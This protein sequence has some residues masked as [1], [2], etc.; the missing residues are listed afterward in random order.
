MNYNNNYTISVITYLYVIWSILIEQYC[1]NYMF[2][3]K[4]GCLE[5]DNRHQIMDIYTDGL[6]LW[7]HR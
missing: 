2:W 6:F 4:Q 5:S 1:R 3:R 7:C